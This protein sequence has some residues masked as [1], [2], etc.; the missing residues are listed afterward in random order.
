M[1]QITESMICIFTFIIT[2]LIKLYQEIMERN[3]YS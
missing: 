2:I 3:T 1:M